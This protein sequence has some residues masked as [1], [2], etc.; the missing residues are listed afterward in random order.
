MEKRLIENKDSKISNELKELKEYVNTL[1]TER[2]RISKEVKYLNL[3]VYSSIK[4]LKIL[5]KI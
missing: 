1:K 2:D 5:R 3:I 4:R